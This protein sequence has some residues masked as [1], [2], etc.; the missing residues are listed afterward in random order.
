MRLKDKLTNS[1]TR[2]HLWTQ[3]KFTISSTVNCTESI[4]ELSNWHFNN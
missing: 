1:G 4:T 2:Y 3:H